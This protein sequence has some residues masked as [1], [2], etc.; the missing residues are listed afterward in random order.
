MRKRRTRCLALLACTAL[1]ALSMGFAPET[2]AADS[3]DPG[4][5]SQQTSSSSA[6]SSAQNDNSTSQNA[7]ATQTGG[8]GSEGQSQTIVQNAPTQ[9]SATASASSNQAAT[10]SSAGGSTSQRNASAA[11]ASANNSN[12]TT[13]SSAE[14][15]TSGAPPPPDPAPAQ[16]QTSSQSAPV[17]QKENATAAS[18]Q[19]APTNINVVIRIDSPGNDG[20]VTQA[21]TSV[22]S[23]IGGNSNAVSQG[24][25]Q[26][27]TGGG[28]SG[29]QSQSADQIAPTVQG[30]TATAASTQT[31]P[32]NANIV[33]RNKS[34]GDSGPLTQTNSSQATAQAAN[35][36]AVDQSATQS[37]MLGGGGSSSG[38]VQS[39]TQSAPTVQASNASAI[40]TQS[41]PAN[42]NV[43]IV[44]DGDAPDPAGSGA[45]GMWIQ[46]WIPL[47]DRPSAKQA[48][49]SSSSASAANSNH[50]TQSATQAQDGAPGGG[51]QVGGAGQSQ[52][53]QQSA[54]T[55]Q[56][57][58][59][60]AV[61]DESATAGVAGP[62]ATQTSSNETTQSALQ[63]GAGEQFVEQ[64]AACTQRAVTGT[65]GTR[66]SGP[67]PDGWM[68]ATSRAGSAALATPSQSGKAHSVP[69]PRRSPARGPHH[70]LP[71]PQA[72]DLP[73][74]SLGGASTTGGSPA[75]VAMLLL[76]FALTA[77]WWARRHLPSALRRL[78]AVVSRLER[79]G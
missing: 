42:A 79:P 44:I 9:Q 74:A 20:P 63:Y 61:S 56:S 28:L 77:P 30:S 16:T 37:Q 22:A 73:S 12:H 58:A 41:A 72:P 54:S 43:S 17:T 36:N 2:A 33:I 21:N 24:A 3:S 68:L 19:V 70:R 8:S 27:Q 32:L 71:L 10:N 38:Q 51:S 15:Q 5:S 39:V 60:H 49:S 50:V 35:D 45:Q 46:I 65:S 66:E 67:G 76:A 34:P 40:S 29:G 69:R 26:N 59:A 1:L 47:G 48:N 14:H 55:T 57:A 6:S 78:M 52:T 13:Q 11:A 23:A 75:I 53:I 31:A 18:T 25:A 4:G 7:T 64:I 62:S